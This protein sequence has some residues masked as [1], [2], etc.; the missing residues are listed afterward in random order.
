[1]FKY[2]LSQ[3]SRNLAP[4]FDKVNCKESMTNTGTKKFITE[5]F[6]RHGN[7]KKLQSL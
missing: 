1:M 4:N 3:L 6:S 7:E 5:G 2:F